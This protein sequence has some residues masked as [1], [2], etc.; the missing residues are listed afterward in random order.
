MYWRKEELSDLK[1]V[2][3]LEI[4]SSKIYTIK[5][6]KKSELRFLFFKL[7]ITIEYPLTCTSFS[8]KRYYFIKFVIIEQTFA[9]PR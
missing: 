9:T 8:K 2:Q 6:K 7:S 1:K 3:S 4:S 5:R